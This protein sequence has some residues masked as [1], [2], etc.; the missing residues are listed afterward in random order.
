MPHDAFHR[1]PRVENTLIGGESCL[2]S[3]GMCRSRTGSET[4]RER[5]L[6]S[7]LECVLG[8]QEDVKVV[9]PEVVADE[10]HNPNPNVRLCRVSLPEWNR[11][12]LAWEKCWNQDAWEANHNANHHIS[13]IGNLVVL[14]GDDDRN[15]RHPHHA[16]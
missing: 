12:I 13:G 15:H 14:C 6:V 1:K 4:G 7:K 10:A 9:S 2:K 8:T 11:R 16:V 5:C 3:C